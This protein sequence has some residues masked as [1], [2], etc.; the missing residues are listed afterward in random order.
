MEIYREMK[1]RKK[2]EEIPDARYFE[3]IQRDLPPPLRM[4]VMVC[5]YKGEPVAGIGASTLGDTCI[6]LLG[7]TGNQGLRLRGSYQLHWQMLRWLK[8][9]LFRWYD[10]FGVDQ[11]THPGTYQF[12]SGLGGKLGREVEYVGAY[13]AGGNFLTSLSIQGVETAQA[14]FARLKHS[15]SSLE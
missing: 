5:R 8:T 11:N 9:R 13:Q 7:A 14:A 15:L 12:K 10:L 6:D 2:W 3:Q 4:M 1:E